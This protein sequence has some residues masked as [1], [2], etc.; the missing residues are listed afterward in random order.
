LRMREKSA[1]AIPVSSC[2]F[3]TDNPR[4]S[5]RRDGVV[6]P[7]IGRG[8][9]PMTSLLNTIADNASVA[10]VVGA[11][12]T[13]VLAGIGYLIHRWREKDRSDLVPSLQN[14]TQA[15]RRSLNSIVLRRSARH[16]P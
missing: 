11:V 13:A 2:A 6:F 3:R 9:A 8:T 1:A 14:V 16:I 12:V 10:A 7:E 4:P 15:E 5:R